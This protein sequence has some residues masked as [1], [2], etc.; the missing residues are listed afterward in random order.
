AYSALEER[1]GADL[2]QEADACGPVQESLT[3]DLQALIDRVGREIGG[4]TQSLLQYMS[5]V[6]RRWPEATTEM[7]ASI[8]ARAD[9]LAFHERVA[10]DDLP[11]FEEE[12]KR[13]LN[14]NTIRELAQFNSWLR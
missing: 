1:L 10:H 9:Y 6:R 3:S 5:E 2:P 13:Q 4:Y 11:R 8:E 14:T 7:D 12:F